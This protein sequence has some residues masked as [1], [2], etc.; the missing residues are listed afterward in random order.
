[1]WFKNLI[2]Y[3]LPAGWSTEADD[4]EKKLSQ[5]PLQAWGG[6]EMESR[7]WVSPRDNGAF[8]YRSQSHWL[9]AMG[10]EQKILPASIIRQQ[11]K[12]RA[13]RIA[14]RQGHP[15]GRKQLRDIREKVETE[16]KP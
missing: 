2:V 16:L 4:L 14:Q 9:L 13:D 12:D 3:R 15:V 7:G 1:M 10:A 11:A 5:Q 6:L 8:L